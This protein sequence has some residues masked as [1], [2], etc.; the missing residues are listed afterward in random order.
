M[1]KKKILFVL[2]LSLLAVAASAQFYVGGTVSL[3]Y[4]DH[5]ESGVKKAY[6]YYHVGP[7]LGYQISDFWSVGTSLKLTHRPSYA[8]YESY[9][10]YGVYPYVRASFARVGIVR[11]F[12]DASVGFGKDKEGDAKYST[13]ECSLRPGILVNVKDNLHLIGKTS[14][15]KYYKEDNDIGYSSF[16]WG[17]DDYFEVGLLFYF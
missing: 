15:L 13:F 7:E 12:A 17:I 2:V 14:L 6:S 5:R 4:N 11:F 3:E 10:S 9:T 16:F 1:E 8:D